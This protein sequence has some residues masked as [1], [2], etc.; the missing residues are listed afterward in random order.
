M[1][2]AECNLLR[3]ERE[4]ALKKLE[5]NRVK[6]ER[7][8]KSAV[9]TLLSG[10]KKIVEGKNAAVLEEEIEDLAAK[11][12]ELQKNSRIKV[13]EAANGSNFDHKACILQ[14][15]L[16]K[17]GGLYDENCVEELQQV[18]DSCFPIAKGSTVSDCR[19]DNKTADEAMLQENKCS[20]RCKAIVLRIVEQVRAET[21]QWSQM[22]K[23]LE[24]VRGEMEELQA[25]RDY[26]ENRAQNSD[27][28][29]QSLRHDVEEWKEKALDYEKQVNEL[30]FK[31]SKDK[32][33]KSKFDLRPDENKVILDLPPVPLGAQLVKERLALSCHMMTYHTN[34]KSC[35]LVEDLTLQE[36]NI[37][38]NKKR[39]AKKDLPPLS[40]AKQLA[41][42]KRSRIRSLKENSDKG[43]KQL[44]DDGRRRLYSNNNGGVASTRSP[45]RDI[46]NSSPLARE[47]HRAAFDYHSPESS[48]IRES[49]RK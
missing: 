29:I 39:R 12:D 21:E 24:Q 40:L 22:Q 37:E 31:L 46:G 15:R 14:H 32:M 20:G 1:L 13:S 26:W 33:K 48:R 25:S 45:L 2:R 17:L 30:E 38:E 8:L 10:R 41:K 28:E 18:A 23:M 19:N 6:M 49:F 27:C 47:N 11:L 9:Q 34:G 44:L 4:F 16:E 5:K 36:M 7:T 3:M 43:N 42:E 35:K